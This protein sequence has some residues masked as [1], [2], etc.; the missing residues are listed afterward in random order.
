MSE[1]R[2]MPW[3]LMAVQVAQAALSEIHRVESDN[4]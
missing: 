3:Q 2:E 1:K 4:K